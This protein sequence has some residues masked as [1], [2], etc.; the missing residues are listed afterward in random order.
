[1]FGGRSFIWAGSCLPAH[2]P[3]PQLASDESDVQTGRLITAAWACWRWGLPCHDRHRPC[4]ALLPHLFTLTGRKTSRRYIFCG[5]FPR[6]SPGWRYQPPCPAQFGLS[7][8]RAITTRPAI[9]TARS[10]AGSIVACIF[11]VVASSLLIVKMW[12][13]MAF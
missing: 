11:F 2:A 1:M 7:S 4:G 10:A 3:Y 9:T 13:F 6:L 5:T 8:S 12:L